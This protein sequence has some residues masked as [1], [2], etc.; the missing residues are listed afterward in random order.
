MASTVVDL[1][2]NKSLFSNYA[3][4]DQALIS[5]TS[6]PQIVTASLAITPPR[7]DNALSF[8]SI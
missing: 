8:S 7:D 2:E 6:S 5:N 1:R 4:D 3:Y